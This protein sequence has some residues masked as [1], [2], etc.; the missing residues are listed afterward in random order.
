MHGVAVGAAVPFISIGYS[1]FFFFYRLNQPKTLSF[2]IRI[3]FNDFPFSVGVRFVNAK[4]LK[5]ERERERK[6]AKMAFNSGWRPIKYRTSFSAEKKIIIN[7]FVPI[8]SLIQIHI[9]ILSWNF[10]YK[11]VQNPKNISFHFNLYCSCIRRTIVHS[12]DC[13]IPINVLCA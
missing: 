1:S 4:A 8:Y 9:T 7:R 2:S 3:S 5:R 12:S 10:S 6:G 13:D 11:I